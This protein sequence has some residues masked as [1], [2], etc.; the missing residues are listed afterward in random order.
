MVFLWWGAVSYERGTM[1]EACPAR[2][3]VV[4]LISEP[5]EIC[6]AAVYKVSDKIE[7]TI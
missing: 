6:P 7:Y 3:S 5:D 1:Y 4:I 2:G